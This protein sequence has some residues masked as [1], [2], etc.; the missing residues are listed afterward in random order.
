MGG[1]LASE[2]L[3]VEELLSGRYAFRIPPF[4]RD[5]A[6]TKTEAVQLVDDIAAALDD[7]ERTGNTTP[8]FLGTMLFVDLGGGEAGPRLVEVVDGQQRLTTLTILFAVLRD[9]APA[10]EQP[11]LHALIAGRGGATFQLQIKAADTVHFAAAIQTPGAARQ[12]HAA[13]DAG[14]RPSRQSIEDIRRELHARLRRDFTSEER[15]KLA[16]F[17]LSHCRVLVVSSDDFDY[18]YQ[19]FLTI[20]DRGKRLTVGDIFRGEILGP[21]DGDQR[22]RFERVIEEMDK[23]LDEAEQTR[24]RGKTFFSHLAA[25]YGWSGKGIVRELRRAVGQL[26]GPRAFAGDVFA[27]MAE[28][29]LRIKSGAAAGGVP[30]E[31]AHWLNALNWLERHGDDDWIPAA[32]L[33]LVRLKDDPAALSSCL[34]EIDRFAHGLM[35][36]GCGRPARQRHFA[37]IV[38]RMLSSEAMPDP[39]ALFVITPQDQRQILR[40]IAVRLHAL[41]S[42]TCRLVLLRLDAAVSGRPLSA[43]QR[44]LDPALSAAQRLT[45]EHVLP[46][47]EVTSG[48]WASLFP[49]SRRRQAVAECLGNLALVT[50]RQNQAAR[51]GVFKQK[52]QVFFADGAHPIHLTDLMRGERVWDQTAIEHRYMTMMQAA[53]RLWRLDGPIPPCPAAVRKS[54]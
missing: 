9:L 12:P 27:P 25:I 19:I 28:A 31:I 54:Q 24:T 43:Y 34:A 29:Y 32:M 38:K 52:Q 5:Y 7:Q 49:R 21:L 37:P 50:E 13:G 18:A 46:R 1:R 33:A 8:Y 17:A 44:W 47:G 35:A 20:N 3:P 48:E 4:Q 11:G 22:R 36:L 39:R 2:D 53:Q 40:C 51:Q 6:W 30:A 45:V 26:G 42:P 23:Y 10:P 14:G 15:Q 16:Q 41:D